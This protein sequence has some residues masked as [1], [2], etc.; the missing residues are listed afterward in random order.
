M[1]IKHRADIGFRKFRASSKFC[2]G[3]QVNSSELPYV[4]Y[5]RPLAFI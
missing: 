2:H 5:P 1:G 4:L 3:G